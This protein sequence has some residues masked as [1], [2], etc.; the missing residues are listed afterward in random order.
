ME[1]ARDLTKKK[2]PKSGVDE[3]VTMDEFN[4]LPEPEKQR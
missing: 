4:A 3:R 2:G 1:K